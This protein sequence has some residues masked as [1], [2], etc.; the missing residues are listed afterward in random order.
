MEEYSSKWEWGK[1]PFFSCSIIKFLHDK[2]EIQSKIKPLKTNEKSKH[3][4]INPD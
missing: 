4:Q 3:K 2:K 1:A